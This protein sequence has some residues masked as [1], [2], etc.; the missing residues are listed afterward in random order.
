VDFFSTDFFAA[1][2]AIVVIDLVLAGDNAIVIALAARSLPPTLQKQ[3]IAWGTLGAIA[4]RSAMT[5]AVVWLLNI[6][7]LMLAGGAMLVWI[8][9]RLL[10]PADNGEE[11]DEPAPTTFWGALRT[12]IIADAVM[13][14]DNVLGVAGAAQGSYLLVV[15]GL[16]ISIPIVIWGSTLILKWVER[17]PVFV[18]VGAGVLAWTA[19]K[20]MLSE[21]LIADHVATANG[22]IL[23]LAYLGVVGGV[24]WVGFV[25]NHRRLESRLAKKLAARKAEVTSGAA[26]ADQAA[27]RQPL[28]RVLVPVDGSRNSDFALRHVVDEFAKDPKMEVHLLNVQSP[29][30]SHVAQFVDRRNREAWHQDEAEKA[31]E[32]ARNLMRQHGVPHTAGYRLGDKARIIADEAGRLECGQ[33]VMATAR[34]NSVTRMLQDSVTNQVLEHT[35][36]PLEVIAGDSVS[37]LE[38]W[39]IPAGIALLL[40]LLATAMG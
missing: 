20:M 3:A 15:L 37:A 1:L 26:S 30:S 9:Y 2:A 11:A 17:F 14:L 40:A 16:L 32:P 33:I 8:A 24:L 34:K 35:T 38:R 4:V 6:P 27:G 13:G 5:M 22:A 19:G 23:F 36:V 25:R 28:R 39:G 12:I 7:G 18:Y 10:V 21:P 31:L 29:F